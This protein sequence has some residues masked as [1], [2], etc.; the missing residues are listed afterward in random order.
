MNSE[1]IK[2]N[3]NKPTKFIV[4]KFTNVEDN[5]FIYNASNK[6]KIICPE[7]HKLY[8]DKCTLKIHIKN[9][10]NEKREKCIYCGGNLNI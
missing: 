2:P 1:D 6:K 5:H 3:K 8:Y 4:T 10:H 9:V 7:C